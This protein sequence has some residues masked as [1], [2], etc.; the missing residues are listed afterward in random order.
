MKVGSRKSGVGSRP[1]AELPG[2]FNL[3]ISRQPDPLDFFE[4]RH[5]FQIDVA[6]HVEI[7]GEDEMAFEFERRPD[8]DVNE[9]LELAAAPAPASFSEVGCYRDR[10][11]PGLRYESEALSIGTTGGQFVDGPHQ[12]AGSTPH[13]QIPVVEHG[14]I[15]TDRECRKEPPYSFRT[16]RARKAT[17][18]FPMHIRL[19]IS[20]FRLPTTRSKR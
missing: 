8:S 15:P 2:R 1:P 18:S 16:N 5:R 14:P 11:S 17:S 19:P 9:S 20:N 6:D 3:E 7:I 10:C 4:A 13:P 12:I